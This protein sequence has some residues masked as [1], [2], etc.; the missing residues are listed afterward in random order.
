MET[1][2]ICEPR[3]AENLFARGELN[4]FLLAIEGRYPA[5]APMRLEDIRGKYRLPFRAILKTRELLMAQWQ[6]SHPVF[7]IGDN[8]R[9]RRS[10]D[11]REIEQ[12]VGERWF[13]IATESIEA[14]SEVIFKGFP[15][16]SLCSEKELREAYR[17]GKL[18]KT[19][20]WLYLRMD[21]S[22]ERKIYTIGDKLVEVV[23][24]TLI[25]SYYFVR[26]RAR[27]LKSLYD[28]ERIR[29]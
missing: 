6:D 8:I 18:E 1:I 9:W 13:G 10:G 19:M 14:V 25:D 4:N 28:K 3:D 22:L 16:E 27:T 11:S 23:N 29:A 7:M 12:K 21:H 20:E 5:D 26:Y 17:R 24:G 2:R 15:V